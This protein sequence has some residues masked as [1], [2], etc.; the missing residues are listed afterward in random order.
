MHDGGQAV[1]NQNGDLV[2]LRRHI[3]DGIGDLFFGERIE[4]R[5]G[6]IKDQHSGLRSNARAME[7]RCFSPPDNFNPPSPIIVSSPFSALREQVVAGCFVQHIDQIF[8]VA[9][10]FTNNRFSRMVPENN[11]VSWVT[12]PIWL[13][14]SSKL[15]DVSSMP[16]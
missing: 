12:K 14:R 2:A 3:A 9:A 15:I 16:L 10:G 7:S 5:S 13:R 1:S 6:F 4:G 11:C 8:F